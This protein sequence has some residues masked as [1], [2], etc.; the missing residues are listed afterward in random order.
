MPGRLCS[1]ALRV[2]ALA[3]SGLSACSPTLDWR[4]TRFDGSGIVA[5][6]PCKPDRHARSVTVGTVRARME[7]LV[8]EA[9]G[10]TFAVMFFDVADPAGVT[11]ALA[12]LRAAASANLGGA[13]TQPAPVDIPGMTPN[14]QAARLT[15]AGRLPDGAPVQ[16]SAAFFVRGLRVYQ[17][18]VIA[19]K[20]SPEAVD[21]FFAGLKLSG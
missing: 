16:E 10:A 8:C 18:T 11:A 13:A 1:L 21:P 12:D 5:S 9:A 14:P 3:V 20:L 19:A 7:M 17:A 2:T 6:F 4:E 15:L